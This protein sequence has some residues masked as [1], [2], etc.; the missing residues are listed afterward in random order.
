MLALEAGR[1]MSSIVLEGFDLEWNLRFAEPARA[2]WRQRIS[3]SVYG[4]RHVRSG[5]QS[6][7]VKRRYVTRLVNMP[8]RIHVGRVGHPYRR[9]REW[10]AKAAATASEAHGHGQVSAM[11]HPS[12]KNPGIV[13]Y[14]KHVPHKWKPSALLQRLVSANRPRSRQME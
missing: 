12:R 11:V 7:T 4:E 1:M 3:Y 6:S 10:A 14:M 8:I 5:W 13:A 9:S 2:G